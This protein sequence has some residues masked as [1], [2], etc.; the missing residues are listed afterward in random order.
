MFGMSEIKVPGPIAALF[1]SGSIT[2]IVVAILFYLHHDLPW[3][4][5]Y[6]DAGTWSGMS[7]YTYLIFAALW[8]VGYVALKG[9]K[10]VGK[11]STW[12]IILMVSMIIAILVIESQ[13]EW[14]SL[15]E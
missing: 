5:I 11:M 4:A 3:L 15:S 9:K 14:A 7:L 8:I 12:V 1:A 6:P 13:L 10:E 2:S